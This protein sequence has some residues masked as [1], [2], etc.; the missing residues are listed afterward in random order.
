VFILLFLWSFDENFLVKSLFFLN[1]CY[2]EENKDFDSNIFCK[3]SFLSTLHLSLLQPHVMKQ[4]LETSN[5][6]YILP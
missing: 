3:I 5:T 2:L 1:G 4:I 6:N